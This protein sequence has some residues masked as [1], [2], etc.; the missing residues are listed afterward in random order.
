MHDLAVALDEELIGDI[1]AADT[2]DTPDIVAAEIE[3]HQV[4]GALLRIGEQFVLERHVLM[5]GFPAR[6]GAGNRPDRDLAVAH[7][8]QN[9]R[10]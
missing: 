1:D 10:T 4:L 2:G 5:R 7:A 6:P 8:H 9:F 3:Q